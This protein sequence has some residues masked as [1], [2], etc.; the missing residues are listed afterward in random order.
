MANPLHLHRAIDRSSSEIF[1]W[2]A[3]DR[4][5]WQTEPHL[6]EQGQLISLDSGTASMT[7]S[8]GT[9]LLLPGR[10]GWLPPHERHSMIS[11]G[12]ISGWS[13]YLPAK[14]SALLSDR[15]LIFARTG[16]VEHLVARIAHLRQSKT[17]TGALGRILAVL[18]DEMLTS[19]TD[20]SY[21]PSPSDARLQRLV[22]AF[23]REP[24]A[25]HD[26][27]HWAKEVG[28]SKRSLTRGFQSQTGMSFG[29]WIQKFRI[30]AATAQLAAGNDVTSVAL[31]CGYGSVGAF[32]RV[33]HLNTGI[34]PAKYRRSILDEARVISKR[35]AI[36]SD[37]TSDGEFD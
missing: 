24:G 33:F 22:D 4:E 20:T 25:Q 2:K 9:W 13:L 8:S 34:T 14:E 27:D 36:R 1:L 17:N 32:I 29:Q 19:S 26:L 21:L 3:E 23:S 15:P 12:S 30:F 37:Y 7:I 16:L 10:I 5:R 28:M 11:N 35:T 6:H 18:A 31:A